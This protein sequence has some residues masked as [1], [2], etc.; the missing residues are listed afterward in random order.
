M[1]SR[2]EN[3]SFICA[4]LGL[5]HSCARR[6]IGRGIEYEELVQAG[7]IGL[8]KACKGF[9]PERGLQF[10]TYAVPVILGEIKKLFRDGGSIKVGRQLK[11]ISLKLARAERQLTEKNGGSPAISELAR[12]AGVSEEQAVQAMTACRTPLSLTAA[13]D[14]GRELEIPFDGCEDRL[15]ELISLNEA[16]GAL[17][18]TE[19][20][21]LQLRF[22]KNKTQ[23]ETAKLLGTT[24]VQISRLERKIID[25]LRECLVR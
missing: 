14:E 11:E 10:S 25:K 7:S 24:Q 22:V 13:D 21:I 18:K 2:S 16:I 3:D 8:I 20:R 5:V 1:S 17:E 4:N 15:T 19:Q 12:F 23:A 9:E 6:F